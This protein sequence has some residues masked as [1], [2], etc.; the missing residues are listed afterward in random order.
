MTGAVPVSRSAAL[1]ALV[2]FLLLA[3]LLLSADGPDRAI[4]AGVVG[5][6]AFLGRM[7]VLVLV[8]TLLLRRNR[9]SWGEVGL[10][11]PRWWR[12]AVAVPVGYLFTV[13]L[14]ALVKLLLIG[15]GVPGADYAMFASL[16]GDTLNYAFFA[17]PMALGS[18]G[19]GEEMIFRGYVR[20]TL[21][22]LTNNKRYSEWAAIVSQ[23][24]LFG[25]LHAYQG[26]GGVVVATTAGLSLG[27]IW[28]FSGKNLWAP[29]IIH[30][31]IDFGGLTAIYLGAEVT[32]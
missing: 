6:V 9:S 27:L 30:A 19:L 10:R 11:R 14:V 16:R 2:A 32:A 26:L 25:A 15:T 7:V 1:G 21:E 24:V 20:G 5:K 29:I 12:F 18:A 31:L 13:L 17:F 22:A 3:F 8:A 23:A 4:A 28:R